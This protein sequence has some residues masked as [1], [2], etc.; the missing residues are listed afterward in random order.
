M[1]EGEKKKMAKER[2]LAHIE[3]IHDI[4]PI[5]GADNIDKAKVLGW[6]II[7]KKQEFK[8]GDLCVFFEIDSKLP[9]R[10]WS[11]FLRAKDFK[12]K[13]YK[14]GKFK[15]WSEGLALPL[16]IIPELS[17]KNLNEGDGVTDLLRVQY[18]VA[19]DNVR[20]KGDP[21]A[22]YKSMSARHQKLFKTKP[23]RWLMRKTWGKKILFFIFGKKKDKPKEFPSWIK[24]TDEDRIENVPWFL[25]DGKVYDVTEKLDGTSSTYGLKRLKRNKYE[26]S[27]CS[28]NVRQVDEKQETYHDHNIYWDMAFKYDIENKLIKYMNDHNNLDWIYIQGEAIGSVQGNPYKLKEDDLYVFNFVTDKDGRFS[29][30]DGKSLIESWGMKWVPLLGQATVPNDMELVKFQADGKSMINTA[31]NR[32]GLVY[33]G[34]DGKA[35][36]KNVSRKYLLKH[37]E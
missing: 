8:E 14:L 17:D 19:E 18:S 4:Q 2:E 21:N 12:V 26:F 15:V 32:E 34:L 10:E 31:V 30:P 5:D 7:V 11:E 36:F 22:K 35:S 6:D 24:K 23:I 28:R 13:I 25:G 20:K 29:S 33:R 9:E 27:V 1:Q 37:Q 16:N 3:R